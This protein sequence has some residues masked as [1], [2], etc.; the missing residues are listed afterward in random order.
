MSEKV[1]LVVFSGDM[2]GALLE[3]M[4]IKIRYVM[5]Q[6]LMLHSLSVEARNDILKRAF[7][8]GT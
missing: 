2:D 7:R 5:E 6:K 1:T 4:E 8:I 3:A